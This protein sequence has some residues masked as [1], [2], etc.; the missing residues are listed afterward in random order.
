MDYYTIIMNSTWIN[1]K[2]QLPA[3]YE[4]VLISYIDESDSHLRYIPSVGSLR[5]GIWHTKEGDME[6]SKLL[7]DY[8]KAH[9]FIVTHWMPLPKSPH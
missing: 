9:N 8:M 7:F 1:V 6:S 3:E 5:N 2:D 4:Y